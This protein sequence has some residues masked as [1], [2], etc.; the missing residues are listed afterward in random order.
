MANKINEKT[1]G[2]YDETGGFLAF[3]RHEFVLVIIDMIQSGKL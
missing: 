2:M 1:K 3:C